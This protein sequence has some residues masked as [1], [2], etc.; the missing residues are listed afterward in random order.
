MIV[1]VHSG[2]CMRLEESPY[3]RAPTNR[4][5]V[6]GLHRFLPRGPSVCAAVDSRSHA[7]GPRAQRTHFVFEIAAQGQLPLKGSCRTRACAVAF[8]FIVVFRPKTRACAGTSKHT[9]KE[10][11]QTNASV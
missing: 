8:F 2:M 3:G 5:H 4:I 1:I 10:I 11:V 6:L 9:V 7:E